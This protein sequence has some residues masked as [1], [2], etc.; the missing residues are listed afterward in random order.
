MPRAAKRVTG[1]QPEGYLREREYQDLARGA[2]AHLYPEVEVKTQWYPFAGEGLDIYAPVVDIAV[3]PFAIREKYGHRYTQQMVETRP[4]V[5]G[6]IDLHNENV[7]ALDERTDFDSLVEF[8]ENA[9]CLLCIEIEESGSRKHCLGNLVNASALGRIGVLV[10]RTDKVLR[11]F[12][13]QRAYLQ[14]LAGVQKN[15]FRTANALIL[16]AAQFDDCLRYH[17]ARLPA[18]GR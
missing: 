18:N 4:F 14:F 2:L 7:A 15:T 12:A 8:N 3:G 17:V 9:R 1:V 11:I 5:Q 13:R 6:L 10:A 16:S